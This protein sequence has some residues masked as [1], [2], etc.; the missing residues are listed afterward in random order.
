MKEKLIRFMYGRN[1]VDSLGK[2]VLAIS[3]IVMLLAGWTDS[4]I[5]SYLSWIGIIYLYFRMFSRN[6]Y[7][8]SSENQ[9]Y[10]NKSYKIRT[11]FYRQKNL[12]LQRKTHH[13][14]KCPTCRQKNRVPRGKGRIEIRCP[15][16]N[17]RFI[18]KS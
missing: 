18:K 16:C 14:Y 17:T 4:L 12:L 1:G 9:W 5:L 2:F 3:I 8:R 13:I 6:I 7:K 10:L 15:K 11:F